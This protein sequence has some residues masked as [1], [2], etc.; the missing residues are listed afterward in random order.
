MNHADL[1]PSASKRAAMAEA[2]AP[3]GD[4]LAGRLVAITGAT[5]G[6]G[7]ALVA[8]FAAAGARVIAC[9][10]PEA[11]FAGLDAHAALHAIHRFDLGDR[12]AVAAAAQAMTAAGGVDVVVANAGWTRAETLAQLDEAALE[13]ELEVNFTGTARL[14]HALLPGMRGRPGAALV[15]VSSVNALAH[16]GNPAYGPAKAALNAWMRAIATEEGRHGIRANAVTP[17]SIRTAAWDHRIARDPGLPERV[18][19]FYPLGRPVVPEEVA[20]AVAFL[21]SPR[22]SGIT[23]VTLPVD[24]GLMGGNLPFLKLIEG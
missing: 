14:T 3:S 15:F 1:P 5:G 13:R 17:G 16:Y 10:L 21:A 19:A 2:S 7:R 22:A 6:L 20:E 9:D 24:A 8:R 18:A 11:S 23:G 4:G 12:A